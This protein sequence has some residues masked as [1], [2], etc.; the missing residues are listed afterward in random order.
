MATR[1]E[2]SDQRTRILIVDDHPIV[3]EGLAEVLSREPDLVVCGEAG[4]P[5][6]ALEALAACRPDAAIVDLS[7]GGASGLDLVRDIKARYPEVAVLVLTMHD[8]ALYA[9]RALRA[10]AR[11]YI[12]KREAAQSVVGALRR[13]L[14]GAIYVSEQLTGSMLGQFI[15]GHHAAPASPVGSLSDRELHV[16]ELIGQGLGTRGIAGQLHI[17]V[18]T[19]EAH[20]AHIKGKLQLKDATELL[21]H[22]TLWLREE[23]EA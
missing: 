11:G 8:E 4:D 9:E 18:K 3:R 15:G 16:F 19:V 21:Q 10:G 1:D 14:G 20:R 2:A 6:A 13:V 7:L 23:G 5:R 12:M 22:A 17:S